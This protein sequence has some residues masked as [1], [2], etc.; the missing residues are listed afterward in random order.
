M[1]H[2]QRGRQRFRGGAS[3]IAGNTIIGGLTVS[4][5]SSG[6]V[7]RDNV[8]VGS[9]NNPV[10]TVANTDGNIGGIWTNNTIVNTDATT[11]SSTL[12]S[13]QAPGAQFY[14]NVFGC[15]AAGC[16]GVAEQSS[17]TEVQG[18]KDNVFIALSMLFVHDGGTDI[19][20]I[21]LLNHLSTV[22]SAQLGGNMALG[23]FAAAM[24]NNAA[25]NDFSLQTG[26]PLIDAS[27]DTSSSMWGGVTTTSWA[28]H[29][30]AARTPAGTSARTRTVSREERALMTSRKATTTLARRAAPG[31]HSG[32][33]S[34]LRGGSLGPSSLRL[35]LIESRHE[36]WRV[37][38]NRWRF[39]S[40]S[41]FG[42][43]VFG[44]T[45]PMEGV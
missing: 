34:S 10:V 21:N 22:P 29:G 36:A 28:T 42:G 17:A 6:F 30:H 40:S 5:N 45:R 35:R 1:D 16:T 13:V 12:V 14:G 18:M 38:L 24:F 8:V 43:G 39:S 2:C 32:G 19:N 27:F 33:H 31:L 7:S 11:T 23:T 44:Q 9:G 3:L 37:L 26:S 20:T 15:E 4:G 25:A 41:S